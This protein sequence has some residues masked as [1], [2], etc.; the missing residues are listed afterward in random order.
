MASRPSTKPARTAT[1]SAPQRSATTRAATPRS[2]PPRGPV[3]RPTRGRPAAPVPAAL[4]APA[5]GRARAARPA[6]HDADL[7]TPSARRSE[8]TVRD[9]LLRA[10]LSGALRPGTALRERQLAET[11]GTTR[12]TVRKVL[13]RLGEEGKL[14]LRPNRGAFVPTPTADDV[15]RVYELRRVLECGAVAMLAER[16]E[17]ERLAP[18]ADLLARERRAQRA[19]RRDEAVRLA[20]DFHL[21]LVDLFGNAELSAS[22]RALVARTQL[23]VALF[24]SAHDG[25]CAV[26][27]HEAV[28]SALR[29]RDAQAAIRAMAGHLDHVEQRVLARMPKPEPDDVGAI[30]RAAME[31]VP[32]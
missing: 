20:G 32:R 9:A 18:L 19:G 28:M 8:A 31:H 13:L 24:E 30:L 27:E 11:F 23:F 26:D 15:R 5:A 29:R 25:G 7:G 10:L 2:G 4:A 22:L 1:R 17:R 6:T 12:G 14:E 3:A 21:V 16:I